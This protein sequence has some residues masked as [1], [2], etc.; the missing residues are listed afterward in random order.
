MSERLHDGAVLS[1]GCLIYRTFPRFLKPPDLLSMHHAAERHESIQENGSHLRHLLRALTHPLNPWIPLF[2]G[3]QIPIV[4]CRL[5]HCFGTFL[6]L[7]SGFVCRVLLGN[8]HNIEQ[9]IEQEHWPIRILAK[10]PEQQF[11]VFTFSSAISWV[12][13]SPSVP[14]EKVLLCLSIIGQSQSTIISLPTFPAPSPCFNQG[15]Q[16]DGSC[17][18]QE[19]KLVLLISYHICSLGYIVTIFVALLVWLKGSSSLSGE[20]KQMLM[21]SPFMC[22]QASLFHANKSDFSN[23]LFEDF[24]GWNLLCPVHVAE[25]KW[26]RINAPSKTWWIKTPAPWP[27]R[28]I[29]LRWTDT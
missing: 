2:G 3:F 10:Q 15:W 28:G 19:L 25:G 12:H 23:D 29:T 11:K 16:P 27:P 17:S 14:A 18:A 24:W 1:L 9:R 20:A 22:L 26:Q 4:C 13:S 7:G 6:G 21:W 5:P 8:S